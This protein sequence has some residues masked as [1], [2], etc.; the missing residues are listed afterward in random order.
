M[1][2]RSLRR[3]LAVVVAMLVGVGLAPPAA[4]SSASIDPARPASLTVHRY[5]HT[6]SGEP[7]SAEPAANV[8]F[9]I[10]RVAGVDLTTAHGWRAAELLTRGD[11]TEADL[12]PLR[13]ATTNRDG[14]AIFRD[15]PVGLY[16]VAEVEPPRGA[17]A[18]DPFFV[19]LPLTNPDD[20]DSWLYDVDVH[21][22]T[23]GGLTPPPEP[24]PDPHPSSPDD[25]AMA[26]TVDPTD[27]LQ[28]EDAGDD[29]AHAPQPIGTALTGS[30]ADLLAALAAVLLAAGAWLA[31]LVR[32]RRTE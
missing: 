24:G 14:R 5:V 1:T 16:R 12:Q 22:K 32:R 27:H 19:T 20:G 23:D 11:V 25:A 9:R 29:A 18:L 10:A 8:T 2:R 26:P 31:F 4:A 17:E 3:L 6:I 7:E 30:D 13:D 21:P 28:G 15:L